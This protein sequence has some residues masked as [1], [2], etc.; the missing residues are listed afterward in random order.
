[1]AWTDA[2]LIVWAMIA[3]LAIVLLIAYSLLTLVI[4]VVRFMFPSHIDDTYLPE[5]SVT[6]TNSTPTRLRG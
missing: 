1:M 3:A 5:T 2:S 4:F 6:K